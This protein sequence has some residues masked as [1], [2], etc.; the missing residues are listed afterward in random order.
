MMNL[1][2]FDFDGTITF[3]DSFT[4]FLR[5]AVA[6][7]RIRT[8]RFVL[9][10]VIVGYKLG[11]VSESAARETAVGFGFRGVRE[12]DVRRAGRAYATDVLPR[13]VRPLALERIHWHKAQGDVV[14]VVSA[15]LDVYLAEWCRGLGVE[16]ICTELEAK[17]GFV[18]GRFRHGDCTGHEK[19]RRIIAKYTLA[20]FPVIYAYGDTAADDAM[21]ALAHRK[22]FRWREL[23]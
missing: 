20:T 11:I 15:S 12:A 1:A 21:L 19:A 10:P 6:P 17:D 2:L 14:V 7:K 8:G 22:Y 3:G 5:F 13:A 16:L 18:T 4:P 23:P 9:A